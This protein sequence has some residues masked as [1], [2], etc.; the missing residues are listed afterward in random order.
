M[1]AQSEAAFP[2]TSEP[3]REPNRTEALAA[4]MRSSASFAVEAVNGGVALVFVSARPE[5]PDSACLRAAA[6]FGS[7]T[8]AR[9]AAEVLLPRVREVAASRSVGTV[10][11]I[12]AL[13]D[14]AAGGLIIRPL[15][16]GEWV[17]GA[18]AVGS[19]ARTVTNTRIAPPPTAPAAI[20]APSRSADARRWG[21]CASEVASFGSPRRPS[22]RG[23]K[24]GLRA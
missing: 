24:L 11:P 13:G 2:G 17:H 21:R 19:P 4:A 1:T 14:R 16:C 5:D 15:V 9:D 12:E 23:V 7:A 10:D 8:E 3:G 20:A 22:V 18:L 6:G